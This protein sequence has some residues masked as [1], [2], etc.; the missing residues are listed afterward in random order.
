[1]SRLILI[2]GKDPL[3]ETGGGHSAYVRSWARAA[4]AAGYAPELFAVSHERG[5]VETE[6]GTVHRVPSPLRWLP[7][8]HRTSFRAHTVGWHAPLLARAITAHVLRAAPGGPTLLHGFGTWAMAGVLAA[9]QL[10]RRGAPAAVLASVYTVM[11]D[12]Y[13]E[14]WRGARALAARR[15]EVMV[16]WELCMLRLVVARCER[17]IWR[18]ADQVLVNYRRLATQLVAAGAPAVRHLPYAPERAFLVPDADGT[19]PARSVTGGPLVVSVSRH[20]SRKG[21]D[22]LLHALARLAGNGVRF[23]ACLLGAG[24]MIDAHESLRDALGLEAR[25]GIPGFVENLEPW[26]RAADVFVLPSHQEGSGSLSLLEAMQ[27]GKAIVAA[28][29]DGIPE[30]V[31]DGRSALLV[32]PRD[33]AALADALRRL[34]AD[35]ELRRRLGAGARTAFEQRF[36]AE[37][38]TAA[39]AALYDEVGARAA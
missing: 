22:T 24:P 38:M 30:D 34:L 5:R 20:D 21:L 37:A 3:R 14:R 9:R 17:V 13:V 28:A 33:P 27:H 39:V 18:E 2:A 19:P 12:E 15:H 32:P 35:A 1:M 7:D 11:R 25:V 16:L 10:R 29:V 4:T 8:R 31:E 26:W 23:D 36:S 6:Y